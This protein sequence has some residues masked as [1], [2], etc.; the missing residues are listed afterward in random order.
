VRDLRPTALGLELIDAVLQRTI[1][2]RH[3]FTLA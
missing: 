2:L 1:D 3:T